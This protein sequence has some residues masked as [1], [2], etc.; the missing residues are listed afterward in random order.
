MN[1][2]AV[3]EGEASTGSAAPDEDGLR[4]FASPWSPPAWMKTSGKLGT[5]KLLPEHRESYARYL[6]HANLSCILSHCTILKTSAVR[7]ISLLQSFFN[8]E[9]PAQLAQS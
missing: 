9:P 3:D 2:P 7:G 6:L 4:L 5:G 8:L 1:L